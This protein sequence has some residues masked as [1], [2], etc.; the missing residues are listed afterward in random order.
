LTV[1]SALFIDIVSAAVPFYLLRP[2]SAV[3]TP[4][5]AAKLPNRELLDVVPQLYTS[6]LSVG[7]Y[8]V[9]LVLSSR[10]LLPRVLVLYFYNLRNIN[11]AYAASWVG[12]LPI[13]VV[14]GVAASTFIFAPFATTGHVM[15]DDKNAAFDPAH[16]SLGEKVWWNV[17]GYTAKTKVVIRR[18]AVVMLVSAASTYLS[19]TQTLYR[20]DS[21]GAAIYAGVWA[22]AALLT[23]VGLG[24]V[25]SV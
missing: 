17:W 5:A 13:T 11:P 18:T 24:F 9:I 25:G 12:V 14:F 19:S 7:I 8:E 21:A 10:Y 1:L 20:V 22:S 3:H 6:A 2:L 4:S 16:A 15:E 23:G